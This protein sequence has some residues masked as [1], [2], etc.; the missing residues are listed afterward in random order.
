MTPGFRPRNRRKLHLSTPVISTVMPGTQVRTAAALYINGDLDEAEAAR[1]AGL[2]RAQ[3][4]QYVR[5]CGSV[6]L[7]PATTGDADPDAEVDARS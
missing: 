6:A 1:H 7:A 2:S 3:L 5:T 4:R